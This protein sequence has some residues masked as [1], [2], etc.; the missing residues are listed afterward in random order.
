M[1][2]LRCDPCERREAGIEAAAGS[3][4]LR[5]GEE[6]RRSD[7]VLAGARRFRSGNEGA[8]RGELCLFEISRRRHWHVAQIAVTVAVAR[9]SAHEQEVGKT[10]HFAV[11]EL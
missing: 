3:L 11:Q 2:R 1:K 6:D 4:F 8:L 10:R 5:P 7:I 9:M